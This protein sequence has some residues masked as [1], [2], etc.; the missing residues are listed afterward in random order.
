MKYQCYQ[1]LK[2]KEEVEFNRPETKWFPICITCK[3][4]SIV[5]MRIKQNNK[6]YLLNKYYKYPDVVKD[7]EFYIEEDDV[8]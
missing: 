3:Q 5:T 1:C 4:N 6:T 2:T 7:I 8:C